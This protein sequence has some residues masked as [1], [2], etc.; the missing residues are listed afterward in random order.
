MVVVTFAAAEVLLRI[1]QPGTLELTQEPCIYREDAELGFRYLENASG[2]VVRNEEIDNLV[3]INS[4]GFHDAEHARDAAPGTLRV[5]AVGDSFTAAIHV[6]VERGWTQTLERELGGKLGRPVEVINLGIGGTGTETHLRLLEQYV[7]VYRPDV[8]VLAF[9]RNDVRDLR[10]KRRH[11]SCHED[12][13]LVYHDAEQKRRLIEFYETRR[14]SAE[15]WERFERWYLYRI[16][17]R[18]QS[19][20]AFFRSNHLSPSRIGMEVDDKRPSPP[21][22]EPLLHQILDLARRQRFA[23]FLVPVPAKGDPESSLRALRENVS[24]ETFALLPLLNPQLPLEAIRERE[25]LRP[26]DL[27]WR[28]GH[29]MNAIGYGALGEAIAQLLAPRIDGAGAL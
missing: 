21:R 17:A 2:R 20:G 24:A 23:F 19:N 1:L 13:V 27:Y 28:W 29:H 3:R 22:L 8:V 9:Y 6:A 15:S 4:T 12:Y 7:P 11:M 10:R 25:G 26:D 5:L 14:P 16:I 18:M